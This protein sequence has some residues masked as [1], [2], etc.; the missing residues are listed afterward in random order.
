MKKPFSRALAA[1][2]SL[3]LLLAMG[4]VCTSASAESADSGSLA[5]KPPMG[6]NTWNKYGSNISEKTVMDATD[7]MVSSGMKDAGY[8]YIVIDDCWMA[9]TRD[10]NGDLQADPG[11]FPHGIKYIADYVHSKGLKLG[12]YS[13]NGVKTCQFK[14]AS[15]G[16][17][18][19]D[20]KKFAEWGVDY[21]KYDYCNNLTKSGS[22][23]YAP[24]FDKINVS[25]GDNSYNKTYEAESSDNTLTGTANISSASCSGGK[26]VGYIGANSGSL[27]FNKVNV[28]ADGTY[29][30][31]VYYACDFYRSFSVSVNG[32]QGQLYLPPNTLSFN[33]FS[34]FNITVNLKKGDN[35]LLFYNS[36]TEDQV[37]NDTKE[38]YATMRDALKATGR[39]ILYSICEWGK[40]DPWVWGKGVGNM[41]R[42][43]A[44]IADNWGSM[45]SNFNNNSELSKYAGP[46]GWNDPDM[47]EVGNGGMTDTEYRTHF[48]LWCI[49]AAPLIAGNDLKNMT[50]ATKDILLNKDAIDIDQD[51][52]GAQ[53]TELGNY[54]NCDAYLKPLANGD[55]AV[56]VLNTNAVSKDVTLPLKDIALD[57]AKNVTAYDVWSHQSASV[58]DNIKFTVQPHGAAM[59]RIHNV[60]AGSSSQQTGSAPSSQESSKGAVASTAINSSNS[61]AALAPTSVQTASGGEKNAH[62]GDN[63][64]AYV[65]ALLAASVSA[66]VCVVYRLRLKTKR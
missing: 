13:D 39:P 38:E 24:D 37:T 55:K 59:Y 46:G 44:D 40:N 5:A 35:T 10:A 20:A 16:N 65:I 41:W 29:T 53:A 17:E 8:T 30:V 63:S 3:S 47:L 48:S 11:R 57:S 21:L 31:S 4:I 27:Q 18:V 6:W 14:P 1:F 26:K 58:A 2:C 28:P 34:K 62:T 22:T 9:S 52:L 56:L 60:N 15:E 64:A 51:T 25:N 42:T 54:N 32:G 49:E 66:C 33:N 19:R 50:Q 36:T 45:L 12:I 43:T 7:A 23:L 61:Q